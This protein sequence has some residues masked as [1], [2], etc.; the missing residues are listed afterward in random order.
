MNITCNIKLNVKIQAEAVITFTTIGED[1][2]RSQQRGR[3]EIG[4]FTCK[5]F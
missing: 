1:K 5:S 2:G 3:G 4:S